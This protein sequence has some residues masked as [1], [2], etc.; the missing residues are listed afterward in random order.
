[1][2]MR[3][4]KANPQDRRMSKTTE[5][6]QCPKESAQFRHK[7]LLILCEPWGVMKNG[8]ADNEL[9]FARDS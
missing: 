1:M 5:R 8:F 3:P 7:S 9:F 2:G 6:Q 4:S